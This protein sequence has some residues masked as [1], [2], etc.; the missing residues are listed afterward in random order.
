MKIL[1]VCGLGMGTSLI[2]RM[3]VEEV[4]KEAGKDYEVEHSDVSA[5]TT[6]P[7]DYIATTSELAEVLKE[8]GKKIIIINNY[9]DKE[10]IEKQLRK[11]G[12][13]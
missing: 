5:A 4:I 6:M 8:T 7:C 12:I 3:N 1:T 9:F 10:E 13:I 11:A 2:L